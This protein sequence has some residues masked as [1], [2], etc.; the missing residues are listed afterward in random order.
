MQAYRPKTRLLVE[1]LEQRDMPS[2]SGLGSVLPGPSADQAARQAGQVVL[3]S[4][5]WGATNAGTLSGAAMPAG[6]D[7]KQMV[8][9]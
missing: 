7:L 1:Q 3:A 9:S 5:G 8:K 2:A 4:F 6:Y